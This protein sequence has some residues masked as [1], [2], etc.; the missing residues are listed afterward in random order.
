MGGES[1]I[2]W[3]RTVC[4][5]SIAATASVARDD[6]EAH[7]RLQRG[8]PGPSA[9]CTT[10]R[11]NSHGNSR[12]QARAREERLVSLG[13]SFV[14]REPH[15]RRARARPVEVSG[16]LSHADAQIRQ[17]QTGRMLRLIP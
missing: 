3:W 4:V 12:D 16:E 2:L 10:T 1:C 11:S 17:D 9:L 5:G 14:W 15:V 6:D 8:A 7:A 13:P